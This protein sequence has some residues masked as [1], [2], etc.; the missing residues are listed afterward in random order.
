MSNIFDIINIPLGYIMKLC[1]MLVHSYG[2]SIILFTIITR[3]LMLP[4]A[5]KQQKN[6]LNGLRFQPRLAEIQ[7]KYGKDREKMA[8]EMQKLSDEGY[9]PAGGCMPLLIQ[10]PIIW[11]LFNVIRSPLVYISGLS[12]D[13]LNN[14]ATAL[15]DVAGYSNLKAGTQDFQIRIIDAITNNINNVASMVPSGTIIPNL[16]MFG[17]NLAE[18]PK[19]WMRILGF[20]PIPSFTSIVFLIPVLS[21]L[22]ALLSGFISTKMSAATVDPNNSQAKSMQMSMMI[23]MPIMSYVFTM[24]V[25]AGVGLYWI[26]SNLIAG[27]Q[28]IVLYKIYDPKKFLEQ[29]KAEEEARKLKRKLAKKGLSES[30]DAVE[31]TSS[32]KLPENKG[33]KASEKKDDKDNKKD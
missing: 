16:N 15:K 27:G 7:K 17:M 33:G 28:T 12:N 9:N 2:L 1:Y 23:L 5:V 25:P 4:L 21:G 13:L 11:G 24:A 19:V 18:T 8:K 30:E 20:I 22:T 29:V 6:M 3:I 26:M 32:K 14:I 31:E 10:M